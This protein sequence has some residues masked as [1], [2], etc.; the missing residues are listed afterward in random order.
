MNDYTTTLTDRGQTSIPALIRRAAHLQPGQSLHW[1]MI[2]DHE[3]RVTIP[4]SVQPAASAI[5]L[6][7]YARKFHPHDLRSTDEVMKE[8]REGEE[9]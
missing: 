6:I 3:F 5:T 2:S 8:L 4:S 9:D 1:E 7:G